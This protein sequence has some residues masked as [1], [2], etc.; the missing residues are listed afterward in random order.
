MNSPMTVRKDPYSGG[1]L[2][3]QDGRWVATVGNQQTAHLFAAAPGLRGALR[4]ARNFVHTDRMSFADCCTGPDGERDE[5]DAAVLAEYDEALQLI[6]GVMRQAEG[7][8]C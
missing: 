5:D 4:A 7:V 3:E 6:D 1:W 8:P 2:I